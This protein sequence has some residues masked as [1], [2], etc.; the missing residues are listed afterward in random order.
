LRGGFCPILPGI[1][2]PCTQK[3]SYVVVVIQQLGTNFAAL[4]FIIKSLV[5]MHHRVLYDG[6]RMLRTWLI[7]CCPCGWSD[8]R[9]SYFHQPNLTTECV[10][11]CPSPNMTTFEMQISFKVC[12]LILA[13]SRKFFLAVFLRSCFL[14]VKTGPYTSSFFLK[15]CHFTWLLW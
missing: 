13:S 5:E 9:S 3:V 6:T 11:F 14:T 12:G 1:T 8:A 7:V 4:C 2:S 10:K 15:M